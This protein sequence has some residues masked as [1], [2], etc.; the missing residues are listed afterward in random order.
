MPLPKRA[1]P[2][3]WTRTGGDFKWDHRKYQPLL[4]VAFLP[5]D[6]LAG[7]LFEVVF[8]GA[9]FFA[10]L[11]DIPDFFEINVPETE[12]RVRALMPSFTDR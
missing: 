11:V 10:V 2:V 3:Q 12:S 5:N 6:F 7:D 9:D 4:V 8:A 1:K